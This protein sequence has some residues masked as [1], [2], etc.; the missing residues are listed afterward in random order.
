MKKCVF[1]LCAVFLFS[2]E[3][4]VPAKFQH[5]A[6]V[7]LIKNDAKQAEYLVRFKID[8]VGDEG[9]GL[10]E[11]TAPQVF[12]VEGQESVVSKFIKENGYT[13]KALVYKQDE[14]T[15]AKT[16]VE[17]QENN[18]VVYTANDDFEINY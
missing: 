18:E 7:T 1:A 15:R 14:K 16:S 11:F 17:V 5:N 13:V 8:K 12:C 9:T 4:A 10:I 3:A 6:L 2:F